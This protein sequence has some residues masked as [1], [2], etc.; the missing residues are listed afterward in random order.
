MD[1]IER[2]IV[3][4]SPG[5][6]GHVL[7]INSPGLAETAQRIA[8]AVSMW[9]DDRR[10]AD[11][12]PAD[13]LLERLE[14]SSLAGI[15]LVWLRLPKALSALDDYAERLASWTAPG[16]RVIAAGRQRSMT[17]SMN[18]VLGRHFDA[19]SA[20]L[21]VAKCRALR[22]SLPKKG[23]LRWPR[24]GLHPELGIGVIAHGE[25]FAT[26]RVDDGTRLLA[27]LCGDIHGDDLLDLGC[28]SGILA[29]LLARANP[30]ATVHAV[31]VSRAAV[32]STTLTAE[33]NGEHVQ[34]HWAPGLDGWETGGLDVIVTNPPFHRG[35]AK[36]SEPALAMF[37]DAARV[38]RPGGELWCVYNSH[39][40]WRKRLNEKI[41]G[42]TVV[43]QSPF[44]T[45][46][47]TVAR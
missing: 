18:G 24:E 16:V 10:D 39:L 4:E 42:T 7:I 13:L 2:L 9:C 26:S 20:S 30:G 3:A 6:A 46:T 8:P 36:D 19:V 31:D 40:P 44:Y 22:A 29:T 15:D 23:G 21:G 45:V 38:L 43:R 11:E 32:E 25:V 37:D 28:G 33:A 47:R 34:V 41:G 14:E 27:E 5:H 17:H 35:I 12:A 1:P